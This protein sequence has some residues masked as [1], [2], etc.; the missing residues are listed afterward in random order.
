VISAL[1]ALRAD[2]DDQALDLIHA[3]L[4][5]PQFRRGLSTRRIAELTG[6]A[7][8]F[9]KELLEQQPLVIK[10]ASLRLWKQEMAHRLEQP[11]EPTARKPA[12][13]QT[14]IELRVAI[15]NIAADF[16]E[17]HC[18]LLNGDLPIPFLLVV[19]DSSFRITAE[20]RRALA[21][22]MLLYLSTRGHWSN[23]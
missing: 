21:L 6:L 22:G 20:N 2:L 16:H 5:L 14:G 3:L 19:G 13:T 8:G 18:K 1:E 4:G 17:L 12:T 11:A 15:E 7:V 9:V 23:P 10:R